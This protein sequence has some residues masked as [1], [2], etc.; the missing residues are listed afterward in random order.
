MFFIYLFEIDKVNPIAA[1]TAPFPLICFFSNLFIAFEAKL[2]TNN[3][4]KISLAKGIATF[5][6]LL[7]L[8]S[9]NYQTKEPKDLPD[10]IILDI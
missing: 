8:F 10:R 2:L 6:C 1:R 9:P 5:V 3:P 4:H 7:V